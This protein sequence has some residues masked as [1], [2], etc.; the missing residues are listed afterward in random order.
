MR[1]MLGILATAGLLTFG[2]GT[3]SA[4]GVDVRIGV[5]EP[6][7]HRT[8][9]GY[10][11][12]VVERHVIERRSMRPTRSRTVCRTVYRERVRATGTIV[13]RPTEVCHRVY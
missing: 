5:G 13:R 8:M 1:K 4:Q 12:P 2:A 11:R 7:H 3:V 6:G 10:G 9:R